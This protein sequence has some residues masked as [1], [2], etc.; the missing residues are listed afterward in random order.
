MKLVGLLAVPPV[1]VIPILPLFAAEGTSAV[2]LVSEFTVKLAASTPPNVTLVVCARPVPSIATM[3]P[4]DPLEG[5]L[6]T[7]GSTLNLRASVSVTLPVDTVTGPVSAS[8]GTVAA[9]NV[10][11]VNVVVVASVPPNLT[12]DELLKSCPRIQT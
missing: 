12:T 10:V 11:P 7:V 5:M 1:L 3:V 8:A 4:T 6:V 2:T 9:R